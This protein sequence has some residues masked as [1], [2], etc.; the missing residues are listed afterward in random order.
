MIGG[1]YEIVNSVTSDCYIGRAVDFSA[2]WRKHRDGLARGRHPNVHLQRAWDKY[3]RQAFVFIPS[4][5]CAQ[6]R[7]VQIEQWALDEGLGAYNL[8]LSATSPIRRGDRRPAEVRE[9]ISRALRGRKLAPEHAAKCGTWRGKKRSGT[10]F[11]EKMRLANA[12]SRNPMYG[13]EVSEETRA[14]MS[15]AHRGKPRAPETIAKMRRP[16]TYL[17]TEARAAMAEAKKLYH[18]GR[19]V[20]RAIHYG[21][22]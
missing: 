19:R 13:R 17:S 12:G 9:R 4:I 18:Q 16:R 21:L 1:V 2:R 10:A 3:G 5:V 15:L 20:H 7:A 8:S 22:V 14:R 6:E 11:L